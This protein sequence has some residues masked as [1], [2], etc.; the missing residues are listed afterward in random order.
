MILFYRTAV[1][2][3]MKLQTIRVIKKV[4]SHVKAQVSETLDYNIAI[5]SRDLMR[6]KSLELRFLFR[7]FQI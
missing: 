1:A 4:Y 6:K 7:I 3:G 5:V 2:D